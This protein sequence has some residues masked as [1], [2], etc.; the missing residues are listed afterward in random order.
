MAPFCAI[1]GDGPSDGACR[2]KALPVILGIHESGRSGE[3]KSEPKEGE[4]HAGWT[5]ERRL[6]H[7]KLR[8]GGGPGLP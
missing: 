2:I 7:R 8:S 1:N 4:D 3:E 5:V 6:Y